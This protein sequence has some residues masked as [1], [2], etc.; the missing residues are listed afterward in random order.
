MKF[1][2]RRQFL[3]ETATLPTMDNSIKNTSFVVFSDDWGEHPSSCQHLFRCISSKYPVIWVNTLGMRNPSLTWTDLTKA[4]KKVIRMFSRGRRQGRTGGDIHVYQPM[5][6]P[7][8]N[9]RIVRKF[10]QLAVAHALRKAIREH[11]LPDPVIVTT[12][13]NASDLL[14]GLPARLV[15]YYCVDDFAE[16]P[17][18][19][20]ASVQRMERELISKADVFVATSNKL[21][22]KLVQYK[23]PTFLLSHGVDLEVFASE[24]PSEHPVLHNIPA[25]RIGYFGLFD[26]RSD[27]Q[28]LADLA[29]RLKDLSF[30]IAGP[31]VVDVSQ[32]ERLPNVF[33]TGPIGYSDLPALA[34]GINVLLIP[35]VCNRLSE[36]ISPLKLKEYLA[37][38]KPIVSTPL[39]ELGQFS[40]LVNIGSSTE[41]L[42]AGIRLC[43]SRPP[44]QRVEKVKA[45]LQGEDWQAKAGEFIKICLAHLQ[46]SS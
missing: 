18:I 20:R 35:Y 9:F 41:E 38:G 15:V 11:S 46:L 37:T 31:V 1:Y 3:Q 7:Y 39:A 40:D 2:K 45:L 5:M 16:W 6:L 23:K 8:S 19:N 34:K 17:K 24:A 12:V 21:F 26:E 10:N 28:L 30:V 14:E 32:L 4:W 43:L 22:Q 44:N 33:F 42:A 27:Q 13:P 25:P 29:S 36:S